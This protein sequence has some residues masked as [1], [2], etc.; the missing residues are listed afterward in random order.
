LNRYSVD[1]DLKKT[2]DENSLQE[3][4]R[5][6]TRKAVKKIF[7]EKYRNQASKNDKKAVGVSYFF[8]KLRF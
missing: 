4:N 6:D 7:E 2:V 1:I 3:A 5:V 8:N